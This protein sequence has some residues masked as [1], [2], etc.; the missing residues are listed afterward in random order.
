MVEAV[1]IKN[2]IPAYMGHTSE[3]PIK[4]AWERSFLGGVIMIDRCSCE[5]LKSVSRLPAACR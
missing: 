4:L 3:S 1:E 5:S 2:Y